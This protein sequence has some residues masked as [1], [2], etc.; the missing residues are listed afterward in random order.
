MDDEEPIREALSAILADFGYDPTSV[1]NGEEANDDYR[2][3][4]S[5]DTLLGQSL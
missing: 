2:E 3:N 1:R 4:I 5:E